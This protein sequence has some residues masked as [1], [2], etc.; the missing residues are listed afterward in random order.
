MKNLLAQFFFDLEGKTLEIRSI[1]VKFNLPLPAWALLLLFA[2]LALAVH[3]FY[4]KEAARLAPWYRWLL[5]G[6]RVLTYVL[7][8]LILLQ[9]RLALDRMVEPR[10]TLALLVDT[11]RSMEIADKGAG[12]D[13][14]KAAAAAMG[15]NAPA[16]GKVPARYEIAAAMLNKNGLD[17]LARLGE[18]YA[19]R[20]FCFDRAAGEVAIPAA[21]APLSLPPPLGDATQLGG[22]L[23]QVRQALRG[24]PVT[25]VVVL[26][27]G[28][29]NRGEDPEAAAAALGRQE[30]PVYALGLGIPETTDLRVVTLSMPELLFKGD[31]VAVEVTF[32]ATGLAGASLPVEV[33]LDGKPLMKKDITLA[34]GLF[35]QSFAIKPDQ[36]GSFRLEVRAQPHPGEVYTQNNS[37]SKPVRVIDDA[38][39]ILFA[40]ETPSWEY[41][42]LKGIF[43]EDKRIRY[44]IFT[45]F[46]DLER[47]AADPAFL[48][49]FPFAD[50]AKN[51][52]VVV[53][54][55]LGADYFSGEQLKLL[56]DYVSEQG[57]S[58][59][60]IGA[61]SGTPA[62]YKGTPL[63]E[64]L[65]VEFSAVAGAEAAP[66][67]SDKGFALKLT[68]EGRQ[69]TITRLLPIAEDNDRL[70]TQL[71]PQF[72]YYPGVRKLKPSAI[73]LAEHAELSGE[74]GPLPL[75]ALQ[76]YGKGQVLFLGVQGIWRWRY[77]MGNRFT[78]RFWSQLIQSM[79][80]PHLL[81][82]MKRLQIETQGREFSVGESIEV[83]VRA[84]GL[85]YLPLKEQ[86][87][88]LNA[89]NAVNAENGES[90]PFTLPGEKERPGLYQ[91][92]LVLKEGRYQVRATGFEGEEPLNLEV[93]PPRF[94]FENPAMNKALLSSVAQKSG[95]RF[96]EIAEAG[97][98][99]E[100]VAGRPPKPSR[101]QVERDLWDTWLSLL[102]VALTCSAEWALRKKAE[103][104]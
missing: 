51:F 43:A 3:F 58:L 11:S 98:L 14:L 32:S 42:Y 1:S 30:I 19:L 49:Q 25:G 59:V 50:L 62:S 77:K 70:W 23:T 74:G 60:M 35:K 103:L 15:A 65:P 27:D 87:L 33:L 22:A 91:G 104:A 18:K 80:L 69:H 71:P 36:V 24:L 46:G 83:Q 41:R 53:L 99:P 88:T 90:T 56:R 4:S 92:A 39:K 66:G 29:S 76:R 84:L 95:G 57:G 38:I 16:A 13:Y 2:A 31:E 86:Q 73:A 61:P 63:E 5:V 94:E 6:L 52:N 17:L 64:L 48:K 68:R 81:G 21:G 47:A 54:H 89:V 37:A 7:L 93:V 79:G 100:F 34:Q 75:I 85:D 28:G 96:I 102:L 101:S 67:R 72:W 45:R 82:H 44:K 26:S 10:G 12:A 97:R 78:H 8:V 20:L 55:N 40:M 9:P